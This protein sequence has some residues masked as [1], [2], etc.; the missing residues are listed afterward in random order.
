MEPKTKLSLFKPEKWL[1]FLISF[2]VLIWTI[3][4]TILRKALPM[5]ALEGFVWGQN[6]AWGY[7]R[8]PWLN[9]W[10]TALGVK[11][12]GLS[13]WMVYFFSQVSVALCFWAVWKLGK[14]IFNPILAVI[15]VFLLEGMQ[16]YSIAAVDFNDNVLELGLWALLI[17]YFYQAIDQQ[18][19]KD[20]VLVGIFAFLSLMAKYFAVMLFL[21]LILFLITTKK[22]RES[23]EKTGVYLAGLIF[24]I[25]VMPHLIW[26]WQHDFATFGYA[27]HRVT[28][29][30]FWRLSPTYFAL[31]QNI[32]FSL[33]VFLF[34]LFWQPMEKGKIISPEPE[35]S[36][37]DLYF[38]FCVALGPF[39]AAVLL[40]YFSK[41]TLH[42]MWGTPLL[43]FWGLLFFALVKPTITK[44]TFYRV[45]IGF[46]TV[47]LITVAV[48]S[49]TIL[50]RGGNSSANYPARDIAKYV[51]E[52][53]SKTSAEL[54]LYVAGDRYSA[55]YVAYFLSGQPKVLVLDNGNFS[56]DDI[57]QLKRE[58]ALLVWSDRRDPVTPTIN[59]YFPTLNQIE[60]KEFPYYHSR[61]RNVE[62]IN[63]AILPAG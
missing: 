28:D 11:V 8:N 33:P 43:S 35:V 32:T 40:G 45:V 63:I 41:M 10:L 31:M 48:Y 61:K 55:G 42:V 22:G 51:L 3:V 7:D 49:Y 52:K 29:T 39:I 20:W 27:L 53:W 21:P 5:D 1:Y 44:K 46:F 18:K 58:G 34:A 50:Y 2:H 23:F 36:N 56:T 17:L 38:L 24:I 54:P 15:A 26:L 30:Y 16:Y 25:G 12:G 47:S 57:I 9:A 13:G 6:L 4:P 62:K 37:Y 19:I 60:S 14:K 59:K